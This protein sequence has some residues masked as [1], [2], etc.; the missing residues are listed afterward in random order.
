M[1]SRLAC[2][3]TGSPTPLSVKSTLEYDGMI[4]PTR[5]WRTAGTY[6]ESASRFHS[7]RL[8]MS[9]PWSMG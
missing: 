8:T 1:S 3:F 2:I 5:C 9:T 7:A 4:V 6:G